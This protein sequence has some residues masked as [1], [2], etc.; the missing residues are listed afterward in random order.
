MGCKTSLPLWFFLGRG[1]V[2]AELGW[3]SVLGAVAYGIVTILL[4]LVPPLVSLGDG[5]VRARKAERSGYSIASGVLWI[6]IL[7]AALVVPDAADGGDLDSALTTWTGGAITHD[8]SRVIFSVLAA[9]I[10]LA[11]LAALGLAIAGVTRSRRQAD[12]DQTA[13]RD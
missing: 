1:L 13:A 2:G 9:V 12:G 4:L 6:A 10:A 11:Y 7:L 3:L 5:E 8:G